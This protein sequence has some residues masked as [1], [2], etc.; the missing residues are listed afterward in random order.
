MR[1]NPQRALA[2]RNFPGAI[3]ESTQRRPI[4]LAIKALDKS[5]SCCLVNPA[6]SAGTAVLARDVRGKS[7]NIRF[8]IA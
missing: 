8:Q 3:P 5:R 6:N 1:R 2:G 4:T 7:L